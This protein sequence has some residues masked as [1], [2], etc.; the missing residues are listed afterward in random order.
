MKVRI[1]LEQ[2]FD[3]DDDNIFLVDDPFMEDNLD[4]YDLENR[5]D[6]LINRFA[7]DIDHMVK[8]DLVSDSIQ[9]EYIED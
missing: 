9:V 3:I 5:V 8:Y 2:T 4:S 7:E 6:I 1:S